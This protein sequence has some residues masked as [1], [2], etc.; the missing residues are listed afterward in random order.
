M[1]GKYI[2]ST[3]FRRN[4]GK[5]R[6]N[7]ADSYVKI[8]GEIGESPQEHGKEQKFRQTRYPLSREHLLCSLKKPTG[9]GSQ[10][11]V[12]EQ[13]VRKCI[14]SFRDRNFQ[15]PSTSIVTLQ[16]CTTEIIN[17]ITLAVLWKVFHNMQKRIGASL[18]KDGRHFKHI[19]NVIIKSLKF[20]LSWKWDL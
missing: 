14:R 20:W 5:W 6:T 2:F 3:N 7:C 8:V 11:T 17:E 9:V 12:R 18:C 1:F 15:K 16:A 13:N 4:R 19:V 10:R